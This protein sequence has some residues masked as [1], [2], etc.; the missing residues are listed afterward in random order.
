MHALIEAFLARLSG[1]GGR[2]GDGLGWNRLGG[3][4]KVAVIELGLGGELALFSAGDAV[5]VHAVASFRVGC[6]ADPRCEAGVVAARLAGVLKLRS[7]GGQDG[8]RE[9]REGEER[10]ELHC[11][12]CV[13]VKAFVRKAV[14]LALED[15]RDGLQK[16]NWPGVSALVIGVNKCN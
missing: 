10:R 9:A 3:L 1:P 7:W 14:V 15:L 8:E 4:E 11:Q 2:G 6:N 16:V 13:S 12:L 5:P